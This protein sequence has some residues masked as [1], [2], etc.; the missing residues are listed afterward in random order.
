MKVEPEVVIKKKKQER[1][2]PS[3]SITNARPSTSAVPESEEEPAARSLPP[4]NLDTNS[5]RAMNLDMNK[6]VLGDE[7]V[8]GFLGHQLDRYGK[9]PVM[10]L[11][12]HKAVDGFSGGPIS[13]NK[14][15][16]VQQW[17]NDT[18]FLWINLGAPQSEVINDFLSSGKQ[19]TWF[20]GSRM[21]DESN[22][23]KH[24]IKVGKKGSARSPST[25]IVL[26]CREY[27]RESKG[28]GPYICCGRLAYQYHEP[29]SRPL[30]FVWNL[31]DHERLM[32][33]PERPV[34]DRFQNLVQKFGGYALES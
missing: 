28:F 18:L 7:Q 1:F 34:A 11:S 5:A 26:W 2:R 27:S 21:H 8:K 25:G 16:G 4:T 22:V 20:G 33:H 14:Y 30:R 10:E 3:K 13:F 15:S 29:G 32:N 19:V 23:I 17:G 6:L 24:L 12:A 31:L 9:A